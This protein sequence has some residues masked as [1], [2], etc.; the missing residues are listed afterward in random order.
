VEQG[1]IEL[2]RVILAEE[3]LLEDESLWSDDENAD[4][5]GWFWFS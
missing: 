3:R 2:G 4:H 1:R 5:S